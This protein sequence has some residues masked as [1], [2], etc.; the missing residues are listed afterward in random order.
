MTS[1]DVFRDFGDGP[2]MEQST[3]AIDWWWG[4]VAMLVIVGALA[5]TTM[6]DERSQRLHTAAAVEQ[7]VRAELTQT[8]VAAYRQGRSDTLEAVGCQRGEEV[9]P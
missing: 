4:A 1:K 9:R 6:L 2:L 7:R 8:V 5:L 3:T